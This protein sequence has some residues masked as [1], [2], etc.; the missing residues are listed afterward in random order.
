MPNWW[1]VSANKAAE[2]ADSGVDY[3]WLPPSSIADIKNMRVV[4]TP[5]PEFKETLQKMCFEKD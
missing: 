2:I 5:S 1:N 4:F 3:V